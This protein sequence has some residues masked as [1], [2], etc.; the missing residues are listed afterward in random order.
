MVKVNYLLCGML[1]VFVTTCPRNWSGGVYCYGLEINVD[2][3]FQYECCIL[4]AVFS[5]SVFFFG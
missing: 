4:F 5:S 2:L 3:H 1:V